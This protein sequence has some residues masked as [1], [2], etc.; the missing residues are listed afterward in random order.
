MLYS[1]FNKHRVPVRWSGGLP[2]R[3]GKRVVRQT[4][5]P[6]RWV[7]GRLRL[8]NT[9]VQLQLHPSPVHVGLRFSLWKLHGLPWR[10]KFK[11]IF[12]KVVNKALLVNIWKLLYFKIK[13][14]AP[15]VTNP[16]NFYQF[17]FFTSKNIL[18]SCKNIMD[19]FISL[20]ILKVQIKRCLPW[21][22][23]YFFF[24]TSFL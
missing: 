14:S 21:E 9:S 17:V 10:C 18:L 20:Y 4:G 7:W 13:H 3:G 15:L 22:Q 23:F 8:W 16:S 1:V 6:P 5:V 2:S 11:K 12:Y 19:Q 24:L